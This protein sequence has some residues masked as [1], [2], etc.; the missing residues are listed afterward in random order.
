MTLIEQIQAIRE[1]RDRLRIE[2]T[3]LAKQIESV[4]D[5]CDMASDERIE[6]PLEAVSRICRTMDLFGNQVIKDRE[7]LA[8]L[9][10]RVTEYLA[11]LDAG[12][13]TDFCH[14]RECRYWRLGKSNGPCT[15]GAVAK[16]EQTTRAEAALRAEVE[17]G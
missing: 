14:A 1:E 12:G 3:A 5:V 10:A 17:R 16:R 7:Q 11:A 8:A 15:C 9:R 6:D 2:V 13:I 4:V